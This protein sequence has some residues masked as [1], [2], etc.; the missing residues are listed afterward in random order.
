MGQECTDTATP[1]PSSIITSTEADPS[2]FKSPNEAGLRYKY[3]LQL[4]LYSYCSGLLKGVGRYLSYR[5]K[6][7]HTDTLLVYLKA[8]AIIPVL[9]L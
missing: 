6:D 2:F 1:V 3:G 7:R 9:L 4:Y 8:T 5:R